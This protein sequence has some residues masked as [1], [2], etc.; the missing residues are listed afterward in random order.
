M[1]GISVALSEF[2][3]TSP[4]AATKKIALQALCQQNQSS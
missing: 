2:C 1:E 3:A 4:E